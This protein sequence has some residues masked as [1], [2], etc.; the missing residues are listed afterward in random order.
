M[1]L[2]K[3]WI[4]LEIKNYEILITSEYSQVNLSSLTLLFTLVNNVFMSGSVPF[5]SS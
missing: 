4:F 5:L 3:N 2:Q 1:Q